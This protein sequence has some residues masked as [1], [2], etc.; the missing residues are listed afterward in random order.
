MFV[1]MFFLIIFYLSIGSFFKKKKNYLQIVAWLNHF[2]IEFAWCI[3]R[4]DARVGLAWHVLDFN[5]VLGV[6]FSP[7]PQEEEHQT[8]EHDAQERNEAHGGGDDESL[9]VK[10]E[11]HGGTCAVG[12]ALVGLVGDEREGLV[13]LVGPVWGVAAHVQVGQHGV[14]A[15]RVAGDA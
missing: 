3:S 8:E 11:R 13:G 1:P 12:I 2:H 7:A 10:G 5:V 6:A 4:A 15:T 14:V 9:D